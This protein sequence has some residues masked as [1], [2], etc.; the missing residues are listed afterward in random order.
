MTRPRDAGFTLIETLVAL[1]V[2]ALSAVAILGAAQAHVARVAALEARAA[3]L[4][5]AQNHL[6][7]IGQGLT[8]A[9][10]PDALLGYR[11]RIDVSETA[12][13]DPDLA[14]LDITATDVDNGQTLARLTGFVLAPQGGDGT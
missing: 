12:T 8:P 1:A 14:R 3:A 13:A 10:Q 6:A 9:T 5:A 4:W 2:L 7:E 11:F